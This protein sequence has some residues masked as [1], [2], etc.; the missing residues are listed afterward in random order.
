MTEEYAEHSLRG[1]S[2]G[3]FGGQAPI[4]KYNYR[5]GNV[6]CHPQCDQP[7]SNRAKTCVEHRHWYQTQIQAKIDRLFALKEEKKR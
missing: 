4:T 1:A 2:M 6:C 7:I 3:Q 5:E